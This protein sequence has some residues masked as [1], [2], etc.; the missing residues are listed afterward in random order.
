VAAAGRENGGKTGQ[1]TAQMGYFA[2]RRAKT[3]QNLNGRRLKAFKQRTNA[4]KREIVLPI[5]NRT[6]GHDFDFMRTFV[7]LKFKTIK[8]N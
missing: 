2:P 8:R 6:C 1:K 3:A 4:F 5:F 7:R